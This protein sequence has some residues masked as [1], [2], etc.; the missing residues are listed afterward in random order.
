MPLKNAITFCQ[1]I[2]KFLFQARL[3]DADERLREKE[4][5]LGACGRERDAE[6][7]RARELEAQVRRLQPIIEEREREI[8][9]WGVG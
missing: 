2:L 3:R 6:R 7:Q 4:A 9:V 8:Q 1:P 5:E